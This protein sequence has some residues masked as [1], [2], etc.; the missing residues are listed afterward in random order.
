MNSEG[1]CIVSDE[2]IQVYSGELNWHSKNEI[3]HCCHC[4]LA[5]KWQMG[6]GYKKG[7]PNIW[8]KVWELD[9]VTKKYRMSEKIYVD[10]E[11]RLKRKK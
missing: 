11:R 3:I 2:V 10:V 8:Y 1:R 5:H 4:G 9:K 7:K 6:L